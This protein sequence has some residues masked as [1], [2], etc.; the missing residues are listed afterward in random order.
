MILL[1]KGLI[2]FLL[3]TALSLKAATIAHYRF[4]G[5]SLD[6][7]LYELTDSSGNGHHGRVIGQ[8]PFELINDIPPRAYLRRSL[9][10]TEFNVSGQRPKL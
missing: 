10:K 3:L 2:S 7:P 5:N 4:E 9:C 1:M 8:E 6:A